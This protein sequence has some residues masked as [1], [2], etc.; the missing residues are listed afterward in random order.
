MH[1]SNGALI[2][3]TAFG[4]VFLACDQANCDQANLQVKQ[5]LCLFFC[6]GSI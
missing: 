1:G 6:L 5:K 4:A 2:H 3:T